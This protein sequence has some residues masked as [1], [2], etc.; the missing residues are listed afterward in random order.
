MPRP[1]LTT[2]Q[3]AARDAEAFDARFA[4][5]VRAMEAATGNVSAFV[6]FDPVDPRCYGRVVI[7]T[8]RSRARVYAVAWMPHQWG[9]DM[10]HLRAHRHSGSAGGGGYDRHSAAMD[11]ARWTKAD[12]TAGAIDGHKGTRWADQLRDAGY[13]VVQAV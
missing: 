10:A 11:G 13:T 7:W 8:G 1:K 12:G 3:R 2:E 9:Q 5:K 6:I 4:D